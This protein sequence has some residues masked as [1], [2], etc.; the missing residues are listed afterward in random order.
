MTAPTSVGGIVVD[1]S[2]LAAL[3]VDNFAALSWLAVARQRHLA[4]W[5]SELSVVEVETIR[6]HVLPALDRLRGH[7]QVVVE[8]LGA[9]DA[10]AVD[11]LLAGAGAWDPLAGIVVHQA[12]RRGWHTV[13]ADPGR[14]HRVDPELPVH[15]V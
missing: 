2:A 7:P 15:A 14:L 3:V 6:P 9:E 10:A 4:V 5:V 13:T 11:K 8:A 1:G 12:R